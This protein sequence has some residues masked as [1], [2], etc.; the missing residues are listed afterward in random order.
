VRGFLAGVVKKKLGLSLAS[1]RTSSG[2][3]YR[4]VEVKSL[5]SSRKAA[6]AA[7]QPNA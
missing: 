1:E 2:R 4:I 3:V 7:E 6:T 5:V